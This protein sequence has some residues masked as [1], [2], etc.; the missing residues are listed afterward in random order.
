VLLPPVGVGL[1]AAGGGAAG[2]GLEIFHAGSLDSAVVSAGGPTHTMF[3]VGLL[4]HLQ[5]NTVALAHFGG[6]AL[7]LFLKVRRKGLLCCKVSARMQ[8]PAQA[9]CAP[10]STS[11]GLEMC[12][13]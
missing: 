6:V 9:W 10:L 8:E 3:T 12:I 13:A 2:A 11:Q 1:L 4:D 7:C 5:E